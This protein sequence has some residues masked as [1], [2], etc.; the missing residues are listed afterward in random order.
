MPSRNCAA[1]RRQTGQQKHHAERRQSPVD[2]RAG[3]RA[4]RSAERG[5]TPSAE[6]EPRVERKL[7]Q[8]GAD[9]QNHHEPR[10]AHR[11]ADRTVDPE[12][13][14]GRQTK[15]ENPQVG[16][17]AIVQRVGHTREV[18]DRFGEKQDQKADYV[19]RERE[20]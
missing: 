16:E 12:H 13:E 15:R 2:R 3:E 19:Q 10:L 1:W 18:Q 8:Q 7:Q 9:L 20:P 17:R 4:A 14:P 6:N 11:V 5:H